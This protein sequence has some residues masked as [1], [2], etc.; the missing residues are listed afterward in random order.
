MKSTKELV[1]EANEQNETLSA[2][3]AMKLTSD[4]EIA[5]V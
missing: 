4:K 3:E 5:F 1:S 2:D